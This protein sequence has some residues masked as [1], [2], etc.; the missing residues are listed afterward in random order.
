MKRKGLGVKAVESPAAMGGG[1]GERRW[2]KVWW[3]WTCVVLDCATLVQ[4]RPQLLR[5]YMWTRFG[6][7]IYIYIL[8]RRFYWHENSDQKN[9]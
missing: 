9:V 3:W 6:V 4:L 7:N 2:R 8:A 1:R 5:L